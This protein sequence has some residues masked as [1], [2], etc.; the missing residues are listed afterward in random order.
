VFDIR[1]D[2]VAH[3]LVF[4]RLAGE[5]LPSTRPGSAARRHAAAVLRDGG[6]A[7][8]GGRPRDLLRRAQQHYSS[9]QAKVAKGDWAGYGAEQEE[10]KRAL[11]DLADVLQ[12]K[13]HT[14]STSAAKQVESAAS[15]RRATARD[16]ARR[17]DASKAARRRPAHRAAAAVASV[18]SGAALARVLARGVGRADALGCRRPWASAS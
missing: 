8:H 17:S 12:G 5:L 3:A 4:E 6:R 11:D 15:R 7:R 18:D 9:G 2:R 16:R 13:L 14:A 10:L 1:D